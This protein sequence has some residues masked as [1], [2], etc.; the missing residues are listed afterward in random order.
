M[1]LS[2]PGV[3]ARCNCLNL[4]HE[5]LHHLQALPTASRDQTSSTEQRRLIRPTEPLQHSLSFPRNFT[6]LHHVTFTTALILNGRRSER[7]QLCKFDLL[8]GDL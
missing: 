2:L 4:I 7:M 1:L 3:F 5:R 8:D 6:R